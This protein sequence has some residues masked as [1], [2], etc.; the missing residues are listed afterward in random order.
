[1]RLW[2]EI[3]KEKKKMCKSHNKTEEYR[4]LRKFIT[5]Y[6]K[7]ICNEKHNSRIPNHQNAEA[8]DRNLL[9]K[10]VLMLCKKMLSFA[11]YQEPQQLVT[12]LNQLL[13]LV[14]GTCDITDEQ[15]ESYLGVMG[16]QM[17]QNAGE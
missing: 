11:F 13:L 3:E 9:T 10:A 17:N 6:I 16:K 5:D 14:N 7:E 12:L 2:D 8:E 4:G 15:E 1:V